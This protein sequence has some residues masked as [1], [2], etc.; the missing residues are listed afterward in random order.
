MPEVCQIESIVIYKLKSRKADFKG[1]RNTV[2]AGT[3]IFCYEV[4]VSTMP[5][6]KEVFY[7]V[8]LWILGRRLYMFRSDV[9]FD[10]DFCLLSNFKL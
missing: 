7:V 6:C 5:L 9:L 10:K 4:E 1:R 3:R 8:K 2:R